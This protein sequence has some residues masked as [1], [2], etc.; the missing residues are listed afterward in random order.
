MR[1]TLPI[2]SGFYTSDALPL[3]AQRAVNWRPSV[4]QSATITDANLFSTEGIA[5]LISGGVLDEC[6]GAHVL[7]GIPYFVISNILYRV[8][9]T[10]VDSVAA[11]NIVNAGT[12]AGTRRVYMADNGT[13]L[14]I[15]AIPDT[16]T[17]GKSYIFTAAPDTLTEITDPNFDGPASSVIYTAGYFSFHKSDGKKFFNSPLNNGLSGYDPLDFNVAVSDPDQIRGQGVLNGQLYIFGSETIQPFRN[18]GRAP[19]PFAPVV[20]STIDIGVFS[21][22]S[23]VKFG[24]G[25]AFVGGGVDESPAIWLVSG[26]QQRKLS[27]IAI[28]N[29]LSKLSIEELDGQ[30]FSWTYAESGAYMLGISTPSTCYVY[31][32]TNDRWHERQ[33]INKSSLSA[34]RV[35]HIV[36]AYGITLVGDSQ[37]G[38]IGELREDESLEY[39]ILTPRLVTSRPFDNSGAAVNVASIEA[40]IES[41]VG[42]ANDLKVQTGTNIAGAAVYATGGSDP[43]ITLSW[44]DDGARTFGGFI[45]RSMGKIGEYTQRPVWNRL[46]RFARQR[47]LQFEV[48]SP[49]KATLIKVEADIG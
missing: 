13:Q 10:L 23:I 34:Y 44:S 49:T 25:L 47:V 18:V 9:R 39:G 17:T 8:E 27:T 45:S 32:L 31:D 16:V 42:L 21:S 38:N 22:Q 48:S 7:A 14:C 24:G 40:V 46:G 29:E 30:V 4:P 19:S 26:G 6:R 3:S 41:G 43:K 28:D 20:G 2:A 5:A 12:I 11:F 37:T 36:T 35:S 33:S 1:T 15:V